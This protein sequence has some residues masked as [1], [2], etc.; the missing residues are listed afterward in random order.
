MTTD[1]L[2]KREKALDNLSNA[3][4][5][6]DSSLSEELVEKL[7]GIGTQLFSA[8]SITD[9]ME[10]DEVIAD[11]FEKDFKNSKA[12]DELVGVLNEPILSDGEDDD[13]RKRESI[14]NHRL[15]LL[16]TIEVKIPKNKKNMDFWKKLY[17]YLTLQSN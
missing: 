12:Y 16:R 6:S 10:I 7:E 2:E 15:K 4:V 1:F 3:I 17:D 9:I 8:N 11:A 13:P 5:G 14:R